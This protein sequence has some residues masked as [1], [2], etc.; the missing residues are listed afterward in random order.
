MPTY[1]YLGTSEHSKQIRLASITSTLSSADESALSA[2]LAALTNDASALL[3]LQNAPSAAHTISDVLAIPR[4]GVTLS[5]FRYVPPAANVRGTLTI[6]G[7]AATRD[8]LRNYQLALQGASFIQTADLPVSAY[9]KDSNIP[10]SVA[11]TL[12]P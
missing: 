8:A 6:S 7:M 3:A 10:F 2:R 5:A 9:A 1:V 4:A 12:K 11:L